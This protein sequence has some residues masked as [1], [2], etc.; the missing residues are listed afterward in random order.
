MPF[1]WTKPCC[2]GSR[3][4][5]IAS[6]RGRKGQSYSAVALSDQSPRTG[7]GYRFL[8]HVD[9]ADTLVTPPMPESW[10]DIEYLPKP[11]LYEQLTDSTAR[12]LTEAGSVNCSY[13]SVFGRYSM[14]Y[15]LSGIGG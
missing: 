5:V 2:H 11:G 7:N 10:Y 6:S 15:Q 1:A 3:C 12:S 8:T 14:S 4:V 9:G 13:S